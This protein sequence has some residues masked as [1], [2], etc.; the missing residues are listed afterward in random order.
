MAILEAVHYVTTVT[1]YT[2]SSLI[3]YL[4][5]TTANQFLSSCLLVYTSDM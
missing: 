5:L 2:I 1:I 4:R 3:L